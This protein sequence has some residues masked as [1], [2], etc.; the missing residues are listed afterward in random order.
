M[1][2]LWAF[3]AFLL[4]VLGSA[5]EFADADIVI[6][7]KKDIYLNFAA[8]EL[9]FHLRKITGGKFNITSAP[10]SK[11]KIFLGQYPANF[12]KKKITKRDSFLIAAKGNNLYIAGL[13]TYK[14][15]DENIYAMMT[16]VK[17]SKGTMA[18]VHTFLEEQGVRWLA[19]GSENIHFPRKKT[20]RTADG[21]RIIAPAMFGR[22]LADIPNFGEAFNKK[23]APEYAVGE[24]FF[25]HL[26]AMRL[27]HNRGNQ[28]VAHT[29]QCLDLGKIWKNHPE[30]FQLM[31]NGKRNTRYLCWTDPA[32]ADIW[33]KTADAYFSGKTPAAAG[34]P[35]V[36]SWRALGVFD[37]FNIDPMDHGAGNDGRCRC[38]RCND[39]RK[40]YACPD[41]SE[42]MWQVIA[43]VAWMVKK[44]YPGK[45]VGTLVY[46]PKQHVPKTVKLPDN[47]KVC[48]CLPGPKEIPYPQ[49]MKR[50]LDI[51]K[52]W[53]K[54]VGR[55]NMDLWTYQ[56]ELFGGKLPGVPEYYPMY[57]QSYM[58]QIAPYAAAMYHE[59]HAANLTFRLLE[60]YLLCHL[61]WDPDADVNKLRKEHCELYYGPAG[62]IMH[63]LYLRLENNWRRYQF[64]TRNVHDPASQIGVYRDFL[65]IKKTAWGKVYDKKE[66]AYINDQLNRAGKLAGK[67][68]YGK[69]I[70]RFRK[71]IY[72]VM[73]RERSEVMD[74]ADLAP[75]ITFTS[76]PWEKQKSYPL[77]SAHRDDTV[78]KSKAT[79]KFRLEKGMLQIRVCADEPAMNAVKITP[80]MKNGNPDLWNDY[81][82]EL[83]F[84]APSARIIH[85]YMISVGNKITKATHSAQKLTYS[86]PTDVRYSVKKEKNKFLLEFTMPLSILGKDG[87]NFKFNVARERNMKKAAP[88]YSTLSPASLL[89]NWHNTDS[90]AKAKIK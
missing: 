81:V 5:L 37:T 30:R 75:D 8:K 21:E 26:W 83:F 20:I 72:D 64:E 54:K 66:M 80:A 44:K 89:G 85:Q 71:Y 22:T 57:F 23:D 40:K 63:D 46:P 52:L 76:A 73:V 59:Y 38:K 58:K 67:S 1:K 68:V 13:D 51:L 77:V 4:P 15:A 3:L 11:V 90:Y 88:E 28:T 87:K 65:P 7:A 12:D 41:D 79:C 9:A 18:G 6:P 34:L 14:A 50:Q 2:K 48:I 56:C 82:F 31:K 43:K 17:A 29:E 70:Q 86:V 27:R 42:I 39:F 35:H 25:G 49:K 84:Y 61:Q 62:K 55:E 10:K 19:P 74:L 47:I 78:L 60:T 36:K 69:R 16:N 24:P 33:L 53:S 32:V 45:F